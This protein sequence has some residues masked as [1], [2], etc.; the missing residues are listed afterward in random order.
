MEPQE[1]GHFDDFFRIVAE[2]CILYR[3][4]KKSQYEYEFVN[5]KCSKRKAKKIFAKWGEEEKVN[6]G[7][8][9]FGSVKRQEI[10]VEYARWCKEREYQW[11]DNWTSFLNRNRES[12][13]TDSS[14]SWNHDKCRLHLTA[15]GEKYYR[16]RI[17]KPK[18][19]R[20]Q[21]ERIKAE[22]ERLLSLNKAAADAKK[23]AE[24]NPDNALAWLKLAKAMDE[25]N[26]PE[27]AEFYRKKAID[28]V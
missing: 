28:L 22:E 8:H 7:Q 3:K 5:R 20:Q 2:H 15:K 25:A 1:E 12:K 24:S 26:L 10:M 17:L 21:N 16:D 19:D 27:E 11:T 6:R 23:Y 14:D 18:L 4:R 9:G 13:L